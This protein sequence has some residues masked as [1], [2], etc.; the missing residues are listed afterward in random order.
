MLDQDHIMND[1]PKT[2]PCASICQQY[3]GLCSL[4]DVIK[5]SLLNK[6]LLIMSHPRKTTKKDVL[7]EAIREPKAPKPWGQGTHAGT[8][9]VP[10]TEAV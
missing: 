6:N 2:V 10:L 3:R 5:S 8:S 1:K 7:N 4:L 9:G